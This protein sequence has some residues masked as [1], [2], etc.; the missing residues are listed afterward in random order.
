MPYRLATPQQSPFSVIYF[1]VAVKTFY[2][3]SKILIVFSAK[4]AMVSDISFAPVAQLDRV[5][6][7]EAEGR[8]F[9]SRR[10]HQFK[11][12]PRKRIFLLGRRG[13][14]KNSRAA[15][16][17]RIGYIRAALYSS[18]RSPL[19]LWRSICRVPTANA[20]SMDCVVASLRAMTILVIPC[21]YWHSR[22][23]IPELPRRDFAAP[24]KPEYCVGF[25]RFLFFQ[26]FFNRLDCR[27]QL[28]EC[29][30]FGIGARAAVFLFALI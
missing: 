8:G 15:V 20:E 26:T 19:G 28:P 4:S 21:K 24:R 27:G 18:S 25:S 6:A 13:A 14:D 10:A 1:P 12:N 9:E 23:Q 30:D 29:R 7:S 5:S 16:L 11:K 22:R 3:A 17:G 2:A